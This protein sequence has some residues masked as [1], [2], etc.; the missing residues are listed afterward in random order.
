MREV[1]QGEEMRDM[2]VTGIHSDHVVVVT[3]AST[4]IGRGVAMTFAKAG[5]SVL[6]HGL[7]PE[8]VAETVEA[9]TAMGGSALGVH[10]DVSEEE[11]HQRIIAAAMGEFGR[12]D[13]LVASAG[14]QTYG[15]S[16]ITSVEEFDRIY[17]VNVRGVFLAVQA[18]I[19]E[20]RK[21]HGTVCIISSVQGVATQRNVV[22]YTTTKGALNAMSRA[23]AVDEAEHA[24]RVNVVLPGSIDTPM[25][26]ASAHQWSDGTDVGAQKVVE[27]WGRSHP[28]GRVG[29]PEE[30]GE[31]CSFLASTSASFVTG[32]EIRVDGGLLAQIG[33]A[34]PSK[35]D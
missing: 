3:G 17:A 10:G 26:R 34:L 23:M 30:V 16:L 7:T 5:A 9:I 28:L 11:T 14:I 32:A 29:M 21:N 15:D 33:A 8:L 6:V 2:K 20:I 35:L 31:V 22:G 1:L 12:I 25:L 18:S 13:H 27:D 19:P 24:V 4:G